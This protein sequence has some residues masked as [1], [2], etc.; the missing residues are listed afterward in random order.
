VRD[1]AFALV[2][3]ARAGAHVASE[4]PELFT[5]YAH[6]F[7]RDDLLFVSLSDR[8]SISALTSGD[9]IIVA[10]GRRYYTN[11]ALITKLA[12]ITQPTA[13]VSLGAIPATNIYVLDAATIDA[14]KRLP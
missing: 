12:E 1:T 13:T 8:A 9:I 11:D 14:L 7:G 4:T 2:A 5:H 6:I 10:R 3:R